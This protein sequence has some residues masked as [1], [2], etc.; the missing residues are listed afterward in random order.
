LIAPFFFWINIIPYS[1]SSRFEIVGVL[2]SYVQWTESGYSG[3]GFL[4]FDPLQTSMALLLSLFRFEFIIVIQK[5]SRGLTK[6]RTVWI[7]ALLSQLPMIAFLFTPLFTNGFGGPIPILLIIG[8]LID[9]KIGVEPPKTP[10]DGKP[11]ANSTE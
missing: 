8:L 6:Q 2:W 1:T 5:H 10:W 4:I 3:S 11:N 9:R 7:S